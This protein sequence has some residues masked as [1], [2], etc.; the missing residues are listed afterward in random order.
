M[1]P[2]D[3]MLNHTFTFSSPQPRFLVVAEPAG[4]ENFMR[5]LSEP[6]QTLTPLS[7]WHAGSSDASL[8]I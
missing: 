5:A 7:T 6:A 1:Q 2:K 8:V 3:L 4:F